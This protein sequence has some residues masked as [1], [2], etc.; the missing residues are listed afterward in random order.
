MTQGLG[1]L[2]FR[3]AGVFALRNLE[4][5]DFSLGILEF[6][7]GILE[8]P[9]MSSSGLTRGSLYGILEFFVMRSPDQVEG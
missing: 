9:T 6:S 7:L 8:F 2:D 5:L 4:F 3:G 1:I